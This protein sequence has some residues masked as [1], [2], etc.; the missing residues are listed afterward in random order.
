MPGTAEVKLLLDPESLFSKRKIEKLNMY[1]SQKR[2]MADILERVC[3]AHLLFSKT[4]FSG[5]MHR[6]DS[7]SRNLVDCYFLHSSRVATGC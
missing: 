2:G 7:N 5:C 6:A 3:H 1:M 4:A